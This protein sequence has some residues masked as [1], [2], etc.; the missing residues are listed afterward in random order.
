[1]LKLDVGNVLLKP[2]HRRQLMSWLKR[3]MRFGNRM[4]NLVISISMH[5]VGRLVE[6]RAGVQD[7][8]G[9]VVFRNRQSHWNDAARN[10]IR[11]LTAYLHDRVVRQ[12]MA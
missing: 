6:M 10:L 5:R 9:T 7:E 1:M 8:S 12:L 11:M 3:A 4:G 2:S